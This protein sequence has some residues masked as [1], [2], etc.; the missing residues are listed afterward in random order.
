MKHRHAAALALAAP[1]LLAALTLALAL[2]ACESGGEAPWLTMPSPEEHASRF[3]PATAGSA[4]AECTCNDCHGAT[5]GFGAFDCLHCHAGD[6]T[7][8]AAVTALHAGVTSFTW[9][10]AA[11]L[12]CHKD[13][14]GAGVDHAPIFPIASG[15]H[16]SVTCSK[17]HVDPSSRE[18]LGC[19]GCHPHVQATVDAEHGLVSDYAFDSARCVRC[20]ADS[21]VD[22]VSAHTGF[23][24][25]GGS[26]HPSS[27]RGECL[28]CH[29][30]LRTD[31]PFGA[32]FRVS[33]CLGC[34][35]RAE[36]DSQHRGESGY[37]YATAACLRCH[38]TGGGGD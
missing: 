29:P 11:C 38:P 24:I 28:R 35:D 1:A 19:A 37:S 9:D 16:A 27:G 30:A 10:S 8:Q 33:D 20:H 3:F 4:H 14:T 7:D 31:K 34:H 12:M 6:H 26:N 22:R 23:A 18:V 13:G 5:G 36:T 21:Q 25:G 15:A 2:A 32:D 17:C